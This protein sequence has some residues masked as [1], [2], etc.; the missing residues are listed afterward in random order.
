MIRDMASAAT[1]ERATD[2]LAEDVLI[3]RWRDNCFRLIGGT[4]RGAGWAN[5]VDI[6][7]G[8]SP[9]LEEAW[10]SGVPARISTSKPIRVGGPYW[11]AHAVVV[12]VGHE[13]V[14]L[15][16]GPSVSNRPDAAFITAAARAV[17][18]MGEVS[19]EK[20]LADEL[21][22]VHAVR[23]MT[24]YQPV[25]VRE[26]A[27]H[28]ATIAAQMLSCDVAAV[29]V[30]GGDPATL[31]IL[32]LT[33][34]ATTNDASHAGRDA[35]RYLAAAGRMAAPVVEQS[36]GTDP[37]IWT[38]QV[39]SRMTLPIGPGLGFGAIALGHAAGHERGFTSLC[40]RIARALADAAEPMLSQAIAHEQLTTEREQYQRATKTDWLTGVGNRAAWEAAIKTM[41][42]EEAGS[43]AVLSADVDDL[44][45]INDEF[46]HAT[47]DN[48]LR[49]TASVMRS[50]LRSCD[51]LCRVGG[52]E[53]L[54]LLPNSGE[55]EAQAVAQRISA[56]AAASDLPEQRASV[57]LSVGWA[58]FDGAWDTTTN[59][60]D[61]RMYAAKR[62]KDAARDS[63]SGARR[64]N[65]KH[66][67]RRTDKAARLMQ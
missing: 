57:S 21:E 63:A 53:F 42:A 48:L 31:E 34:G 61:A 35:E 33:D 60:S 54:V 26:T 43:Y 44:K 50:S 3:F 23:A 25:C 41:P 8:D 10:R 52:D 4:G 66:N 58:I 2:D 40:Q 15:F 29:R 13:H 5:I 19:A 56:A 64:R 46:G 12:P 55:A 1:A 18:Q 14:V 65:D 32:Q 47:G 17:G 6:E 28:I 22:V 36:V 24:S 9:L 49:M 30:S 51:L 59:T 11:A 27:R 7:V 39:V 16:G 67:R 20:L 62:A 37:E 38:D 45:L